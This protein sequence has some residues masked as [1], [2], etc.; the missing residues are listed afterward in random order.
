MTEEEKAQDLMIFGICIEDSVG[1]RV[2][3]RDVYLDSW[4]KI[5][6]KLFP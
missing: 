6:S 1:T 4:K 2:D 3:P 5:D